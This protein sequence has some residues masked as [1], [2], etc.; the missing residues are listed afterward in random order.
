MLATNKDSNHAATIKPDLTI[1]ARDVAVGW[2]A[3]S[4]HHGDE[5]AARF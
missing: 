2:F 3:I 5:N 4:R 1:Y